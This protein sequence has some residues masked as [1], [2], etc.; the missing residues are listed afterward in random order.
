MKSNLKLSMKSHKDNNIENTRSQTHHEQQELPLEPNYCQNTFRLLHQPTLPCFL[1]G[2]LSWVY[3]C[4]RKSL[5]TR[6]R[7]FRSEG[8][9][10]PGLNPGSNSEGREQQQP[11]NPGSEPRFDSGRNP[12][13]NPGLLRFE[14]S[15]K[16]DLN[17]WIQTRV[18]TRVR[19]WVRTWARNLD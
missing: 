18:R 6:V 8:S 4:P 17:L 3:T 16:P 13:S 1:Q 12:G 15:S 5:P 19:T 11:R 7:G 9:P 14:P 10:Q 2:T